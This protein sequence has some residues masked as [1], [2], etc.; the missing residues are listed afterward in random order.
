MAIGSA[1]WLGLGYFTYFFCYGIYLPFWGVWLKGTGL[2]AEKIGLLLGCGM[3][4]RFVGSLL[5]ASQV[6]NPSRLITA[7]RLLALMTCLFAAGFWVGEQWMWLLTVMI[8]FN[9]F[10]SPLVPL[11]DALAATWTQQIGLA[12]GPVRL[13]G[14]LAFVISSALTGVLVSAWSSNAILMLLSIGVISMLA[15]MMLTPVTQPQGHERQGPAGGGWQEWRALLREN[16]VWR[17]MLCV[18]LL[19]GAHAAYYG[20]SAIWWQESGY[21]ASTVGYLW[22]LGV[23]AEIVVFAM[24]NRLFRRWSARDLLLLSGICAL[25]RWGLMGATTALPLLIV[26]QILHCGSFTV[27]HLAAMRFIA[28]RQGA[29]VIRLQSL[30]SALAMGGGIAIMTMICGVLFA[31]LQGHLFWV[32]ALVALP[33]L[34]LRPGYD[35]SK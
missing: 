35:S 24:S 16:A 4:A 23:V 18:T 21:S 1:R 9:L 30:Y 27:C 32:M 2:D 33:A 15:G 26:A 12:Y 5:I 25:I 6:K 19:Q 28:A 14:S 3:V 10:F 34:F 7:L 13:W 29:E 11:S 8:G 22:S 17:F 31:H 20:F